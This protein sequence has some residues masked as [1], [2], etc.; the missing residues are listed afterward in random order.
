SARRKIQLFKTNAEKQSL[1]HLI[2][3][4]KNNIDT[5][6]PDFYLHP[7]QVCNYLELIRGSFLYNRD[8]RTLEPI[9]IDLY[10]K[11]AQQK[12]FSSST[13]AYELRILYIIAHVLYRNQK[14]NE[15][16]TYC[17]K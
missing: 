13:V 12:S 5:N 8:I 17:I 6:H 16:L 3:E 10:N 7:K 4:I 9:A 11:T 14:L 15:S 2:K 1:V